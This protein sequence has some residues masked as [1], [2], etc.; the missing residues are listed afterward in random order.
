MRGRPGVPEPPAEGASGSGRRPPRRRSD[1]LGP[2]RHGPFAVYWTGGFLS[3]IG[4]W[5]QTVAASVYV[6][7][8]TGSTIAVGVLNFA[9]FLPIFLFSIVGGMIGDRFDRRIV[10]IST[11]AI[12]GVL[13]TILAIVSFAGGA[14]ELVVIVI[15]FL[16]NTAYAV[17]KPAMVAILPATVPRE[18]LTDAVGINTLQFVFAQMIGPVLAAVMIATAGISWAFALNAVSYLAPIVAMLALWQRGIAGGVPRSRSGGPGSSGRPEVRIGAIAYMRSHPWV[19]AL[20]LGVIA[21]SAPLEIVRTL[22]PAIAESLHEPESSAGFLIAAQSIGSAIALLAFVP[23][24]R[25]GRSR[26]LARVGLLLQGL[27]LILTMAAHDLALAA[28][29]GGLLGFGFSLCFPVLTSSL[30]AEVPD[31]VRGRIMSAHQMANL[32]NRPFA[33][34]GAGAAAAVVGAQPAV[35]IGLVLIPLG[36]VAGGRAWRSLATDHAATAI[37]P[38]AADEVA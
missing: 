19:A 36:L 30:Q 24:R 7:H 25:S 10:V 8:L 3:N 29:A 9:S 27:G 34:L 21:C 28:I 5:L 37:V 31:A 22:S 13:A 26:D 38:S 2:F 6:Y 32:G 17:A 18:E 12:S 14:S 16:L 1:R 4:T 23:L 20:L 35:L 11:H 15:A 33:A